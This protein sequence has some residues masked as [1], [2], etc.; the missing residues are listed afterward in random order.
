[1]KIVTLEFRE[2]G[3]GKTYYT[4]RDN[5]GKEHESAGYKTPLI[6]IGQATA[7]AKKFFKEPKQ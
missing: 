4:Y 6:A 5:H 2:C 1:M 7:K 3:D